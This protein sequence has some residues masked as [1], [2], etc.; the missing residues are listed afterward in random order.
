MVRLAAC[1]PVDHF[2]V[3]DETIW[4]HLSVL[5]SSFY[6]RE[7]GHSFGVLLKATLTSLFSHLV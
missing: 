3:L 5:V 6:L 7:L 1:V 2:K 4:Y